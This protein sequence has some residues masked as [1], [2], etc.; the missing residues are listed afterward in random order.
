MAPTDMEAVLAEMAFSD[1]QTRVSSMQLQWQVTFAGIL[2]SA[3]EGRP[4]TAIMTLAGGSC[5]SHWL[6]WRRQ[7][8]SF[9]ATASY[10][11]QIR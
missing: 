7:T 6:H 4:V 8:T 11:G 3:A 10:L 5:T 1:A 9:V 2:K